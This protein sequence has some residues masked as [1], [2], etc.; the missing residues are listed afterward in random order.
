MAVLLLPKYLLPVRP[1]G[2]VFEHYAVAIDGGR[3][4]MLLPRDQAL[5]Q[6]PDA[7]RVEL[8]S[9]VLM[10][11]LINMHTHSAMTL[12]RGYADDLRLDTWLKDHIWPAEQRW[13]DGDFV[14][15]GT[16]LALAEMIRGGTTC[17]NENYFYPDRIAQV[18]EQSGMRACIGI[19]VID[20]KTGW[21]AS[22]DE[23]LQKGLDVRARFSGC[24]RLSFAIA[25]HSLYSVSD[26]AFVQIGELSDELKLPVHMHLLEIEWEIEHSI[27]EHGV[28]P[29]QRV[30][31]LGLLN[32]RL[33]AVHMAH[34]TDEDLLLLAE[35]SVNVVHCPQSNLKL[36]SGM[37]RVADLL[38]AGVNVSV[39]TDGAAANNDLDLLD[40]LQTAALLA[41]G[42]AS[43]PG[44]LAAVAAL[45]LVTLN[46]AQALGLGEQL[47]S[48]EVG[49]MADL[50]AIDLDDPRTQPVHHVISQIVY[51]A[52]SSQ[53]TDVWVA[54]RRLLE[55][56]TLTTLDE[57]RIL[58]RAAE[59][60]RVM[61]AR[62]REQDTI[63]L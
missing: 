22:L 5:E 24:E 12:L 43:D 33:I 11:G 42:V 10:P 55:N 19:P 29:L 46:A 49:K 52:C 32:D 7:E 45:D 4:Q 3:I 37:C 39:G 59:W 9:H 30:R 54:G 17:F 61:Q 16:E 48:I 63:S 35:H 23:Y 28:R 44:A 26:R 38:A 15:D 40:E 1:L 34:L 20:L 6:F 36:A 25:P 31:N 21:A 58:G 18:V 2:A 56:R 14:R 62:P 13:A 57:Q 41:K 50:C 27:A 47:G 8:G 51:A 53:V 60:S